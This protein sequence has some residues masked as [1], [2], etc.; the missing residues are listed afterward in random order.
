MRVHIQEQKAAWLGNR[1][2]AGRQELGFYLCLWHDQSP[3][4]TLSLSIFS[5][6]GRR[7]VC[8]CGIDPISHFLSS[9]IL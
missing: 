5:D 2:P 1:R 9:E 4:V 3:F 7:G 8:V 6:E